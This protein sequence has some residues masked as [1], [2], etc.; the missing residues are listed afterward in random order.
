MAQF[1]PRPAFPHYGAIPRSYFLG[2]HRAG[3]TKMKSM[4]SLIDYVVECRDYRAPVTSINPMFEEA[5]GKIRRLI[6]YTKRDL[7][8]VLHSPKQQSLERKVRSFDPTSTVFFTDSS[9]RADLNRII[10]HLRDDAAMPDKLTGCRIMVV[11]MPNVGKSTLIN[12]LRNHGVGKAKALKTGGQPGITRKIASPV[13]II[14][15]ESGSHTYVLDTPGVFMPYVP[16]AE[17]MLK[18]ALV[19]C[20]KDSVISPVTLVD[21]LLY[22]INLHDPQAYRR[23]SEPTNEVIP[24]LEGFARQ[25]GLL[26]KGGIPNVDGAALHFISKWR[27]GDVGKFILDDLDAEKLRMEGPDETQRMSMSQALKFERVNRKNKPD[28]D[29]PSE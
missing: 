10:K 8:G 27:S 5:L 20:V 15:R 14:E 9:S 18:L 13:K 28:A 3:L 12:H 4:L 2:H 16:D 1:I 29:T 17:N 24:L 11:G 21:Y 22:K 6:V 23:W 25:T 26:M 19:G 7:G